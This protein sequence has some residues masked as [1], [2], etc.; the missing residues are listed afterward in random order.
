MLDIKFIR[1][2]PEV[3][4][5][6]IK[7]KKRK[8]I[9]INELLRL[10]DVRKTTQ[11]ELG[12]LNRR[13][14]EAAAARNIEEGK[15]V[16]EE[17]QT[18]EEKASQAEKDLVKLLVELPNIPSPDTPIGPDES[19]NKVVRQWGEVP[20]F[21]FQPKEHAELGR[22]LGLIDTEKAADISGSRFAYLKGDLVLMQFGLIS[23]ALSILGS[24]EKLESIAKEAGISIDAKP[25]VPV[26]PP[27]MMRSQVMNRMARLHPIDERYYFEKDDLVFVGSAE[28]TLG[29]LHMSATQLLFAARRVH[30]ERI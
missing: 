21:S 15:N 19:G 9:D 1:E 10:A 22:A 30:M 27:V 5:A 2:N 6:A 23:L 7:N 26:L 16:K 8:D 4:R 17:L 20:R 14:N 18:V 3:V 11:Q 13:K 24:R 12:E 28:H 25:F 29:P